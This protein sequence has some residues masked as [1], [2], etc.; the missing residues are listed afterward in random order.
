MR[1]MISQP[2]KGLSAE[3]IRERR[4]T[5]VAKLEDEGHEVVDTVFTDTPPEN[6]NQALWCLRKALQVMS[7][8]DAVYFM[9]GW[10]KARGCRIEYEACIL[11]GIRALNADILRQKPLLDF[12]LG[13][14]DSVGSWSYGCE[15]CGRKEDVVMTHDTYSVQ[16]SLEKKLMIFGDTHVLCK[17]HIGKCKNITQKFITPYQLYLY[18]RGV[19]ESHKISPNYAAYIR[20][21]LCN[22]VKGLEEIIQS[23]Q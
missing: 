3:E 22:C 4:A 23:T 8:V 18:L 11:Y 20:K 1:V 2:M 19:R 17:E 13:N 6:G 16:L 21:I 5:V 9:E 10:E 15:V 12:V 14:P 7:T